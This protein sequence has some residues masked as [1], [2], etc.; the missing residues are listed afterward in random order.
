MYLITICIPVFNKINFTLSCLKDLFRQSEKEVEVIVV[1]NAST[2]NTQAE[3]QKIESSNF[4]YIRNDT[5]LGFGKACNIA[6]ANASSDIVCFLNNDIR[7]KNDSWLY[8]LINAVE[9]NYLV[10]PT[11]GFVD[12]KQDFKFLYETSDTNKPYNYVSGWCLA[13]KKDTWNKLHIPRKDNSSMPQIFD[14]DYWLYYEDTD[15]SMRSTKLG[16]KFKLIDIPVVH[17]GRI[18]SS[19]VNTNKWY[20]T[21]R[22]IFLKKWQHNK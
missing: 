1:D 9:D 6:Y 18:S 19:Q 8:T 22:Q 2:D 5:N 11:G 3:M 21:S 15:A 20:N 10:G 4:R 14:E 17:F 13:G 12:P 7:V 16:I